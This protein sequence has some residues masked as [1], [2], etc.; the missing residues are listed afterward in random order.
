MASSSSSPAE[1]GPDLSGSPFR[2]G[3]PYQAGMLAP[4]PE[5]Y[6]PRD[7]RPYLPVPADAQRLGEYDVG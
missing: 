2:I 1:G 6:A 5:F 3:I 7:P 4:L